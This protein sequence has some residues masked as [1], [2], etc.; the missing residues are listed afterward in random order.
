MRWGA[1]AGPL[2]SQLLQQW[3]SGGLMEGGGGA[4]AA[5]VERHLAA[6]HN[7][8]LSEFMNGEVGAQAPGTPLGVAPASSY[9]SQ[10][11]AVSLTPVKSYL[12]SIECCVLLRLAD[13]P[14][15]MSTLR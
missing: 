4:F 11:R 7:Q 5:R 10:P 9:D 1:A 6:Y 14:L 2:L 12:L 15:N 3:R 8:G 13:S